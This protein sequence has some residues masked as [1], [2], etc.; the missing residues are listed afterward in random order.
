MGHLARLQLIGKITYYIGWITLLCGGLLHLGIGN[1]LFLTMHLTKRNLFEIS[2][3]C[4]VI[5]IA[6]ELRARNVPGLEMS[7]GFKKAA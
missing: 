1:A 5:C 7:S 4:F 6:S 3:T 2:V